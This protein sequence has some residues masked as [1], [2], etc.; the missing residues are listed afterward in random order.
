M[1]GGDKTLKK[2]KI[3]KPRIINQREGVAGLEVAVSD[4]GTVS[5]GR[6]HFSRDL[7]GEG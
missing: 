5:P 6:T 7:N 4:K 3:K 2:N 1:L